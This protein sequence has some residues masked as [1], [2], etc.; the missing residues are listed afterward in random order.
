MSQIV[1]CH[2][3]LAAPPR[4]CLK[5]SRCCLSQERQVML[6][7]T[8]SLSSSKLDTGIFDIF[9]TIIKKAG[10]RYLWYFHHN[11]Q[12]CFRFLRVVAIDNFSNATK[13]EVFLVRLLWFCFVQIEM[14]CDVGGSIEMKVWFD[15]DESLVN[16]MNQE[17]GVCQC[18]WRESNR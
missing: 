15:C 14:D 16:I 5:S 3:K 2:Q 4:R 13:G 1:F 8:A 11:Y 17:Q 6:D 10:Y 9:T 7:P 18:P 12:Q